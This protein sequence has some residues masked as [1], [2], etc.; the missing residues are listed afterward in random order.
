MIQGSEA[1]NLEVGNWREGGGCYLRL[2][3]QGGEASLC[4]A[5]IF[6]LKIT[7]L[8][9]SFHHHTGQQRKGLDERYL[10]RE[11]QEEG[12]PAHR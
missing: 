12:S 8:S 5:A 10:D 11:P 2:G 9:F 4:K 7:S 1:C 3:R 6:H